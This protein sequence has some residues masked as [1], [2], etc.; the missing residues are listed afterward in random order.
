MSNMAEALILDHDEHV[1][2]A[3]QKE[4]EAQIEPYIEAMRLEAAYGEYGYYRDDEIGDGTPEH[5]IMSF[6]EWLDSR[7]PD[8][9]E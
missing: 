4:H 9:P 1:W 3:I 8:D 7:L 5:E 2:Q 6:E